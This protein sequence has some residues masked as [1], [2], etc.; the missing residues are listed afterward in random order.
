MSMEI[1]FH[2]SIPVSR[3]WDRTASPSSLVGVAATS[4]HI[5]GT[6]VYMATPQKKRRCTHFREEI[7]PVVVVGDGSGAS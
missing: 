3:Y 5:S 7:L 2:S 6:S 1:V 4:P